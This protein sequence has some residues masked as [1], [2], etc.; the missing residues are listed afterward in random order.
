MKLV[1]QS[2]LF[3]EFSPQWLA[4][5]STQQLFLRLLALIDNEVIYIVD[6]DQKVFYIGAMGLKN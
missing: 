3:D 4:S 6:K 2:A 1:K 5:Q